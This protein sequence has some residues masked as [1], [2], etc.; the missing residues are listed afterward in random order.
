MSTGEY[1]TR[2][3][4]VLL[5]EGETPDSLVA[6]LNDRLSARVAISPQQYSSA[7]TLLITGSMYQI[8][9]AFAWLA[10]EGKPRFD[11]RGKAPVN[12]GERR[13]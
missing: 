8:T 10:F 2:E 13:G 3:M 12:K 1:M 7:L 6:S 9:A 5:R 4:D 11:L